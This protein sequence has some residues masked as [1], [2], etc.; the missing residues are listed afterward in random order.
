MTSEQFI[1]SLSKLSLEF[2]NKAGDSMKKTIDAIIEP[3]KKRIFE[4]GLNSS[5]TK[6]GK[7]GRWWFEDPN[8]P[9]QKIFYT[10]YREEF[11]LQ[12]NYVDL[13][14]NGDLR[15]SLKSSKDKSSGVMTTDDDNFFKIN[16]QEK[17]QS[18]E[19]YS[20]TRK[21]PNPDSKDIFGTTLEEEDAA[22]E[23]VADYYLKL[24]EKTFPV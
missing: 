23:F 7:Y 15:D 10:E 3:Y 22:E 18:G 13:Q 12:T 19:G 14:F 20:F 2:K 6:I 1:D 17:L 16:F 9:G 4:D 5:K 8:R 21:K 24:I 11:G